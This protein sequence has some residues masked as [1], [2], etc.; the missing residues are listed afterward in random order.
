MKKLLSLVAL[1]SVLSTSS[2]AAGKFIKCE[3]DDD[4]NGLLTFMMELEQDSAK[5]LLVMATDD[6]EFKTPLPAE[7]AKSGKFTNV[8]VG[9]FMGALRFVIPNNLGTKPTTVKVLGESEGSRSE[10][11]AVCLAR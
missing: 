11:K 5:V 2:F 3:M 8:D 10:S 1:M 6:G 9:F 4:Q 7:A